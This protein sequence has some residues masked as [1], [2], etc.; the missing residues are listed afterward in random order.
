M[1][2]M[3]RVLRINDKISRKKTNKFTKLQINIKNIEIDVR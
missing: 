1:V 2:A 3:R